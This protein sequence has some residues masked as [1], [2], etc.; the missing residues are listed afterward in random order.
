MV[1]VP[2]GSGRISNVRKLAA[3]SGLWVC[4]IRDHANLEDSCIKGIGQMSSGS[5]WWLR[6]A[7]E[8]RRAKPQK[9]QEVTKVTETSSMI[10]R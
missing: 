5:W 7:W 8:E 3:S 9:C 6:G 2:Q 1:G 10:V 4:I